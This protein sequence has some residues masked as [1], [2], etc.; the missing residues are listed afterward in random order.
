MADLGG[1]EGVASW[2]ESL[3]GGVILEFAG[4]NQLTP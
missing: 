1:S 3:G 2:V 4:R